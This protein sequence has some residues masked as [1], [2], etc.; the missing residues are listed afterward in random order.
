MATKPASN[1]W[2]AGAR[3]ALKVADAYKQKGSAPITS[4]TSLLDSAKNDLEASIR[5]GKSAG[6]GI[7]LFGKMGLDGKIDFNKEALVSRALT[8]GADLVKGQE[9]LKDLRSMPEQAMK[10]V[11][12]GF[13]AESN[14]DE[15]YVLIDGVK[16]P[17]E[18]PGL[19]SQ[20]SSLGSTINSFT[21]VKLFKVQDEAGQMKMV[22]GLISQS[23]KMGIPNTFAAL[24]KDL[25]NPKM[26]RK[27]AG[28][29][30]GDVIH[31][32]DLPSMKEIGASLGF[33]GPTMSIPMVTHQ[34]SAEFTKEAQVTNE[35][36]KDR[37]GS[38]EDFYKICAPTKEVETGTGA[39]D[40]E[41]HY[42]TP[43]SK[44]SEDFNI[45]LDMG[46]KAEPSADRSM[47]LMASL[48]GNVDPLE[49][50]KKSFPTTVFGSNTR[51]A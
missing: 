24:T 23:L 44:G 17:L 35:Q 29:V 43:W 37:L 26:L 40:K 32:V 8:F 27:I 19:L 36:L 15:V 9:F 51:S 16:K 7:P 18:K 3:D 31:S 42:V 2:T 49:K 13:N 38:V 11:L 50:L 14:A 5:G 46:A 30:L 41:V 12:K 1:I 6:N 25:K 4:I 47:A 22:R 48:A 28:N 45:M 39:G 33:S 34:V 10:G 20:I 21:G